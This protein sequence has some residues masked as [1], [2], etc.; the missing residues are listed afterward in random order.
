ML[1]AS[2]QHMQ[3]TRKCAGLRPAPASDLKKILFDL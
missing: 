3:D 1:R 2:V